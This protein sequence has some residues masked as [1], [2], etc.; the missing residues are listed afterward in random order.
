M[1]KIF[2]VGGI[3]LC[4]NSILFAQ[5]RVSFFEE[6]IDFELDS[7]Y[8]RINGIYSFCNPTDQTIKQR[9][10]FPFAMEIDQID[11][12]EILNLNPLKKIPFIRLKRAIAFSMDMSPRDTV[13]VNI[14][15]QQKTTERNTYIITSTKSWKRSLEKAIYTLLT[16]L[17]I[18]EK[19]FSYPFADKQV[20]NEAMLYRWEQIDFMPDKEFEIFI[21]KQE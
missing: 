17:P 18:D 14:C 7:L 2:I 1:K 4:I 12:I 20:I 21:K 19:L 16:S 8:F 10:I 13:D 3:L 9:I 11:S 15:Y 5:Q 6:H